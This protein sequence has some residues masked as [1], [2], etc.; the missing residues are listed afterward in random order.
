MHTHTRALL[1][2]LSVLT[3]AGIAPPA[4]AQTAPATLAER[5]KAWTRMDGFVPMYWDEASGRLYL[6]ISRF[7]QEF[8]YQVSLPAGLG[9]NPVGLDRG[10]LGPTSVVTF[11]RVG[12]KVLLTQANYRFRALT[13]DAAERQAVADSFARSV[14]WGFKV[15]AQEGGRVL[16]DAT[17]FVLR[18]AHGVSDRLRGSGQGAYRVDGSR[19]ALYLP[20]TRAFPKNSEVEAVVTLV[21]EASPGP[22][23][24]Q[25]TPTGAAVTVRQHH[26][27]VELPDLAT[28]P[29][30]PRVADPRAGG[31]DLMFHDYAS[32]ITAPI[33]KH[34]AL[35][36]HLQKK[37][38]AAAVS[39]VVEPI[40]YYVDNGTPE[41]IRTA[42][43]EGAQWWAKAFEAAGFRNGFQVKVLPA[44]ADPMDLRYNMINWVHRS[45][46]GW[47]YGA[48]VEDPRTG[49]IL[50]G[51]VSLGSLRVR[52]DIM[53]G[54]GLTAQAGNDAA[55]APVA[56]ALAC[57]A[58]DSPDAEY[59]AALDPSTDATA[60]ALARIRQ[61]SAHEVGHTLGFTHNFAAST[62]GRA[63]VMDYPAPMA[64]ITNGKVDLSEAYGVGVGAF[65]E[66]AVKYAYSQFAPGADEAAE[67]AR[68]V[69]E[70]TAKGLLFI[71][72]N[73]ARPAG[74]AHPLASLWDNGSDPIANLKHELAV[75]ALAMG[76]F[77]IGN[78]PE[79]RSLSFLEQQFL[80]LY[81]HHRYQVQATVKS[82]GGQ[83]YTYAVRK[84]GAPAPAAT[85]IVA[86][87]VQRAALDALLA[88][89][90]PDVLVV[91]DRILA[92]LQP[93]TEAF[94]GYN[95]EMFPRRTGL[96]FD[97]AS[98]AAIAADLTISGL[99][100]PERAARLVEFHARDAKNPGLHEVI[101]AMR[102]ALRPASGREDAAALA[103]RAAQTVFAMRLMEL[104]ANE[105]AAADVRAIAQQQVGQLEMLTMAR[106][107]AT[108]ASPEW[109]AHAAALRDMVTRYQAR[110][111]SP[112]TPQKL[113]PTPAGDPIGGM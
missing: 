7:D 1:I 65:D 61:L 29:F 101:Q 95:T 54:T 43:V 81:L 68:L 112:Y 9:S 16:V 100:N 12:P 108:P 105:S 102:T 21:T 20:R 74:A 82:V 97:P 49:Q 111:F 56:G 34:W 67:L 85:R 51:N 72:D 69:D 94:G 70:A 113:L 71:A 22:L 78:I 42:L 46:R 93:R 31:I 106:G 84:G 14:L 109:V 10:Q 47:S 40:V 83:F 30:R 87:E 39:D 107:T 64:K 60:M 79:G 50:K 73:D 19:T 76:T 89:L 24:S 3:A 45:T 96:T 26:S 36:H 86:P 4:V 41:P 66:F 55:G 32:P 58:G 90:S 37:D 17:D 44:D 5:T 88:T 27:F 57:A 53:L 92:L 80:P 18:D 91:P 28:H 63:S 11:Q 38:P 25:V 77:D 103:L 99:L 59:L 52:Q 48:A 6:E 104:G 13:E 110:P 33:E 62:Y 2:T 75:R 98:A 8:L 35:R 23:V 15:E